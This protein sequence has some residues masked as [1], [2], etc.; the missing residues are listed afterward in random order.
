LKV[1]EIRRGCSLS[2]LTTNEGSLLSGANPDLPI[3]KL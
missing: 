1:D 3:K 2:P